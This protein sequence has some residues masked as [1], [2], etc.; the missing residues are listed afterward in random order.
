MQWQSIRGQYAAMETGAGNPGDPGRRKNIFHAYNFILL[1]QGG[2]A[3]LG[4]SYRILPRARAGAIARD[5]TGA[6][7]YP[8][9][10]IR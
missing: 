3:M 4:A 7:K 5:P 1:I 2:L 9:Q 6:G 8:G 10:A